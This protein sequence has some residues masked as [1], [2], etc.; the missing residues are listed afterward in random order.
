[1]IS[2]V[3]FEKNATPPETSLFCCSRWG[4]ECEKKYVY[5]RLSLSLSLSLSL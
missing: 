4:V 3:E 1:M 5:T 2:Y